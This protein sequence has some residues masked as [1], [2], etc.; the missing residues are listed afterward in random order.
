[1]PLIEVRNWPEEHFPVLQRKMLAIALR[2]AVIEAEVPGIMNP[3]IVTVTFGGAAVDL[4]D[5]R[6]V[7]VV[8]EFLFATPE[9]TKEVLDRLA[10]HLHV[11]TRRSFPDS[12]RIEV[13]IRPFDTTIGAYRTD[14]ADKE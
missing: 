14:W 5:N 12:W 2:K 10:E 7:A 4:F 3:E 9:R 6:T 1:M 11:A 8:V 13:V